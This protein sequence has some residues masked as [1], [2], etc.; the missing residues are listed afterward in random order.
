MER[1][2]GLAKATIDEKVEEIVDKTTE[3][4]FETVEKASPVIEQGVETAKAIL[5]LKRTFEALK[6]IFKKKK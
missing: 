2:E 6:R 4:V 5:V 1:I 3:K